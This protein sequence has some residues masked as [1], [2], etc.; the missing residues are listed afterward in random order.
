MYRIENKTYDYNIFTSKL[1]CYSEA[2]KLVPVCKDVLVADDP[3]FPKDELPNGADG[4][5]AC[6]V[7][8]RPEPTPWATPNS[9]TPILITVSKDLN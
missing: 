5:A 6:K 4:G 7:G 1:H 9:P 8:K 3:I 2:R